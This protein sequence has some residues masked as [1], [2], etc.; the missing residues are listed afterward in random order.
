[1]KLYQR[2]VAVLIILALAPWPVAAG[3]HTSG[4]KTY[5]SSGS[6]TPDEAH[7][8]V[9]RLGVGE[10]VAVR[11]TSGETVRGHIRAIADDHFV[12]LLDRTA[13][14]LDIAYSDV[15]QLGPNPSTTAKTIFV[16]V[17]VVAAAGVAIL[18]RH[19]SQ[20]SGGPRYPPK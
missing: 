2:I 20:S 6:P 17:G 16:I 12:L 5:R 8:V 15:R 19:I 14:P 3:Q 7:R 4:R 11:L 10:H 1:M 18:A 13:A 9:N